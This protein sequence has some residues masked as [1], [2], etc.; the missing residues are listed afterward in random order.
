MRNRVFSSAEKAGNLTDTAEIPV[1][2][3]NAVAIWQGARS[4]EI[5]EKAR[6]HAT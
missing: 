1:V 6:Q 3:D 4:T 2:R 5:P